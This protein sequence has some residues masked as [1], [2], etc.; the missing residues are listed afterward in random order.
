MKVKS[1][2][3]SVVKKSPAMQEMWVRSLGLE[4]SPGGGNSNCF[5]YS[6]LKNSME[7]GTWRAIVNPRSLP[8]LERNMRSR[9]HA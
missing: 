3:G 5:Q 2:S 8:S 4:R 6:C 9:T 1:E 7:R